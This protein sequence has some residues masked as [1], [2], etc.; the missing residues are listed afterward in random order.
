ML[1]AEGNSWLMWNWGPESRVSEGVECKGDRGE[2]HMERCWSR[3]QSFSYV[4][5]V[6]SRDPVHCT[7]TYSQQDSMVYLKFAKVVLVVKNP[8]TNT[9]DTRD[10]SLIPGVVKISWSSA[11]LPTSIFLPGESHGQRSLVG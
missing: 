4:R 2:V 11:W 5:W 10:L 6:N 8:P 7:V 9:G 1:E 3:V